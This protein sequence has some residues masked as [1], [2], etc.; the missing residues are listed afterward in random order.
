MKNTFL[1]IFTLSLLIFCFFYLFKNKKYNKNIITMGTMSGWAPYV[2]IDKNGDYVGFDVEI[3]K[4]IAE[5]LN[6]KLEIIDMD[7]ASLITA[8]EKNKVDFGMTDLGITSERLK[9]IDFVTYIDQKEVSWPLVFWKEIPNE[10]KNITDL[11]KIKN[12][13]IAVEP[14]STQEGF[15]NNINNNKFEIKGLVPSIALM[16]LKS[17]KVNAIL[18]EENLLIE[19]KKTNPELVKLDIE[20]DE[21]YKTYGTGIGI[22]KN[23]IDLKNNIE[24]I[25]NDLNNDG[26]ILKLK[27]EFLKGLKE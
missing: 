4:I 26:T 16:E 27:N 3:A 19:M 8:I 18:L 21:K 5:R 23:N 10:I 20:I 17:G 12:F 24:K 2:Y 11:E 9:R 25:I 13:T 6:K 14:G 15:L 1:K 7:T 22:N